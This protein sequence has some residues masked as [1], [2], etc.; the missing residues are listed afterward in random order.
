V[1][2]QSNT[3]ADKQIQTATAEDV[4][5]AVKAARE[6]FEN[7]WGTNVS[8]QL[9]GQLLFALATKM[10]EAIEELAVLETLDA[11]KPLACSS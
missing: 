11:G 10:E 1:F 4:D 9:R 2:L 3:R 7:T 6:A 5:V 8:A